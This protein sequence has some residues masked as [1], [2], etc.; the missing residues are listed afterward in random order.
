MIRKYS[1][2]NSS[3]LVSADAI[4]SEKLR[5]QLEDFF[6]VTECSG[7]I[8]NEWIIVLDCN[9]G[10][11][12][13]LG[14][15]SFILYQEFEPDILVYIN[16]EHHVLGLVLD[17]NIEW[18]IQ[19]ALRFVRVI[20][21][22]QCQE[23]G[24]IFLHGGLV[25]LFGQGICYL[26]PK[27]SGKTTSI[28]AAMKYYGAAFIANDD[29]SMHYSTHEGWQGEGWPRSIVIRDDVYKKL[30]LENLN[31][32]HPL[33]GNISDVCLYPEQLCK[34]F[35]CNCKKYSKVAFCVLPEFTHG[36]TFITE[37]SESEIIEL[38]PQF[39]LHNPGKYNEFLLPFF[40]L[41]NKKAEQEAKDYFKSIRCIKIYQNMDSIRD[42]IDRL[43]DYVKNHGVI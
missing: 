36:N 5:N 4:T 33:N 14:C 16:E 34:M 37:L 21:R 2:H 17:S 3:V 19:N 40:N 10:K 8:E 41:N 38:I 15:K 11:L 13:E 23:R 6:D 9:E 31:Y 39:I 24:D 29:M 26:G 18:K 20:L 30:E 1:R 7:R 32:K 42:G 12:K 27:K 43:V 35:K 22:M 25:E 28:L